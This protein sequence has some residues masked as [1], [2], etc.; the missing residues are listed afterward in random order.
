VA[1]SW[2]VAQGQMLAEH[3][4]GA[5][6]VALGVGAAALEEIRAAGRLRQHAPLLAL[7]LTMLVQ[8]GDIARSRPAL[9]EALPIVH[10]AGTPWMLDIALAWLAAHEDRHDDAARLLG[11]AAYAT[12]AAVSGKAGATVTQ[13][14]QRL[15]ARLEQ[16][17]GGAALAEACRAGASLEQCDAENLALRLR[18]Q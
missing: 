10:G 2:Q 7:W 18:P 4:R 9:A 14:G 12:R 13:A 11:W 3:D 15:R 6:D 1:E 16:A 5:T 8:A 17:M